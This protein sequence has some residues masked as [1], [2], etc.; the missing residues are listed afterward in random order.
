MV[1]E[2]QMFNVYAY[3][4][5]AIT[6]TGKAVF[7]VEFADNYELCERHLFKPNRKISANVDKL[8]AGD[9]SFRNVL[10]ENSRYIVLNEDGEIDI[11][12]EARQKDFAA[13]APA[14]EEWDDS[15]AYEYL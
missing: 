11:D 4:T 15:D 10:D 13:A 14:T 3:K 8:A 2:L 7:E 6:S 1:T 9:D 12:V 5:K